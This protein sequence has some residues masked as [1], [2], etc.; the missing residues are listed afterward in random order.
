MFWDQPIWEV[1]IHLIN[2]TKE[3]S[4]FKIE[5]PFFGRKIF[6]D[7][8]GVIDDGQEEI[9]AGEW[10]AWEWQKLDIASKNFE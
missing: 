3:G 7:F 6:Q 8:R 1:H 10:Q 4:L 2:E 5:T 9:E